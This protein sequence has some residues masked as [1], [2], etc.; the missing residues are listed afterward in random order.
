M[1]QLCDDLEDLFK[2]DE[3]LEELTADYSKKMETPEIAN[4]SG[5]PLDIS[6]SSKKTLLG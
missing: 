5:T 4:P 1:V 2:S 6:Y 3:P